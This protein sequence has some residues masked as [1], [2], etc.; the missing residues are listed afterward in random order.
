[1]SNGPRPAE[2][3]PGGGEEEEGADARLSRDAADRRR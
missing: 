2:G 1:M 3:D